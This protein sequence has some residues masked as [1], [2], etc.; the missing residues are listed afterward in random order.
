M[1]SAWVQSRFIKKYFKVQKEIG[2]LW[3]IMN[4]YSQE[5]KNLDKDRSTDYE[6]RRKR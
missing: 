3:R 6:N 1:R 4:T 5:I 2:M